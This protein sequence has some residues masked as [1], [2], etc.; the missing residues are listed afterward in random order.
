M[1]WKYNG[2]GGEGVW[3]ERYDDLLRVLRGAGEV[4][5]FRKTMRVGSGRRDGDVEGERELDTVRDLHLAFGG[6]MMYN[7]R[8]EWNNYEHVVGCGGGS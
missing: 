3:E 8:L 7:G 5:V 4:G 1:R 2:D 6:G